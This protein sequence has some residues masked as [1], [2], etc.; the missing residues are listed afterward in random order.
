MAAPDHDQARDERANIQAAIS[1]LLQGRPLR[2]TGE[3]TV[4]QLAAEAGVKRW[5]LTHQHP[6]LMQT[7]QASARHQQHESP[8]VTPWR[9]R[10][11]RL[12][13][14][15]ARLRS[16]NADLRATVEAYAQAIDNLNRAIDQLAG[17]TRNAASIKRIH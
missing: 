2:S 4:V 7:F 5:R 8:L 13:A 3:L 17:E 15:R 16:E 12:E 14:D 6:D 11:E 10:V 1:R 9:E